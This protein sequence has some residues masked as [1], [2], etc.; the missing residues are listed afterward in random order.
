[1]NMFSIQVLKFVVVAY[2]LCRFALK[3]RWRHGFMTIGAAIFI[4]MQSTPHFAL[5]MLFVLITLMVFAFAWI[6]GRRID[7]APEDRK[8]RRLKHG[9]ILLVVPLFFFKLT[10]VVVP[11]HLI[12][13]ILA[14][15][16]NIEMSALA[17]LGISYFS[18]R[19]MAY[20]I[21]I[22]K[23]N[24]R[25]VGFWQ[26]LNYVAFWPTFMAGPIERPG[27][28]FRQT[29]LLE[30]LND[31][32]LRVGVTRILFGLV[33]KMIFGD[34]FYQIASPYLLMSAKPVGALGEWSS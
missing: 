2:F 20:L 31:E 26:L 19:S 7:E 8:A 13:N 3:P 17:P 29:R 4:A 12:S 30:K 18:F 5:S 22:R 24:I 21:E 34:F 1:M 28:F 14:I 10:Q 32:D 6:M 11:P 27:P 33:K 16:G 15:S 9:I 23:G 25:P